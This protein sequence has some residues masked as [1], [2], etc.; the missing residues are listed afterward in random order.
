MSCNT[1]ALN[2]LNRNEERNCFVAQC[3]VRWNDSPLG[4]HSVPRTFQRSDVFANFKIISFLQRENMGLGFSCQKNGKHILQQKSTRPINW[5]TSD[6]VL[7]LSWIFLM[8]LML[9]ILWVQNGSSF[10]DEPQCCPPEILRMFA[11][12]LASTK[13]HTREMLLGNSA[14][15]VI[16][17]VLITN[18]MKEATI[19]RF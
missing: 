4:F 14:I 5:F 18:K 1:S 7:F 19:K 13:M 15:K 11:V 12:H 10:L 2:T 8:S 6:L 9:W 16:T 17:F 3:E